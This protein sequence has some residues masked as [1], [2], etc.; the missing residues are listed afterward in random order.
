MNTLIEIG[1]GFILIGIGITGLTL[2]II[3]ILIAWTV[4][5]TKD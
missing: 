4:W 3:F 2:A 5:T 1:L